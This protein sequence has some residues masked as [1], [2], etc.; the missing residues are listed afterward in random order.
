MTAVFA[1]TTLALSAGL[2]GRERA[3]GAL[4]ALALL[5]ATGLFLWEVWSPTDGFRMP[6]IDV[7]APGPTG[8]A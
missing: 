6:W 3:A 2:W 8:P 7:R 1:A 4:L 5:L